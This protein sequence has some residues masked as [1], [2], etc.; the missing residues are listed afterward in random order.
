M[1]SALINF[2]SPVAQYGA[3]SLKHAHT[4]RKRV[5]VTMYSQTMKK[6]LRS[7]KKLRI[8]VVHFVHETRQHA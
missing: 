3:N 1:L 5:S 8:A 6:M 2:R 4:I 7:K